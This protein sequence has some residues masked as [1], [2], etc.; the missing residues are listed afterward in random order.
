M[1][2]LI[3]RIKNSIYGTASGDSLNQQRE[4]TGNFLISAA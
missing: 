1:Q 2:W 3:I 4:E